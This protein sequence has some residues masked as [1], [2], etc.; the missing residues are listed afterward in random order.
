MRTWIGF[1][2]ASAVMRG[3]DDVEVL[4]RAERVQDA[5]GQHRLHHLIGA[6]RRLTRQDRSFT[7]GCVPGAVDT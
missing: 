3:A 5:I 4:D 2:I 6:Q 1:C 7:V